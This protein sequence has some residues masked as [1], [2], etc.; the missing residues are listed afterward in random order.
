V[1]ELLGLLTQPC[2]T[3]TGKQASYRGKFTS[4]CCDKPE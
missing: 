1:S 3:Y 4:Y 2:S